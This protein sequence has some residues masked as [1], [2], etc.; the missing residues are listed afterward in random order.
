MI[1]GIHHI[2]FVVRDLEVAIQRYEST[3]GLPKFER[4]ELQQRGVKTARVKLGDTWLILV[5]PL[6]RDSV[7]GQHLEKY[8][9]GFFL[10][11][12]E[13]NSLNNAIN[14]VENNNG[15]L[16]GPTRSGLD[17]WQVQD[18]SLEQFFGTQIQL[19]EEGK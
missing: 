18:L 15:V 7:P 11:S 19:T 1:T 5:Q 10:L 16:I 17:N 2:N 12:L 6:D 14:H 9:E 13:T 3:L 4:G 8:G